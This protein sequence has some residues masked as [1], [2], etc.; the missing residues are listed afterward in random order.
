MYSH[1]HDTP[2]TD[3]VNGEFDEKYLQIASAWRHLLTATAV[4]I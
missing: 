1:V 2:L 4:V 3:Q